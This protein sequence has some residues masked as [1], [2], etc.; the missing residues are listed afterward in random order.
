MA[1]TAYPPYGE[2][3]YFY[4]FRST[5]FLGWSSRLNDCV[6]KGIFAC[7]AP[8]MS[9]LAAAEESIAKHFRVALYN[10]YANDSLGVLPW[11]WNDFEHELWMSSPFIEHP[12]EIGFGMVR[13]N[14][15]PK[16]SLD[17]LCSF[18]EF[19]TKYPPSEWKKL[20]C[21]AAILVPSDYTVN[22]DKYFTQ[23]FHHYIFLRQ[24]HYG[25]S[26]I[27]EQNIKELSLDTEIL[28][29]PKTFWPF[30]SQSLAQSSG[31]CQ[32]WRHNNL[33]WSGI[34]LVPGAIW[35]NS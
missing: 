3:G 27:W 31:F 18:P 33:Y 2:E 6:N 17:E 10:N 25:V 19:I 20:E 4:G 16:L 22:T 30:P 5:Y 23:S 1:I 14:G 11:V 32:K 28:V 15:T 26:Y 24:A 21:K 13:T 8:G 34:W 29:L 9:T 7:E 12:I 35:S